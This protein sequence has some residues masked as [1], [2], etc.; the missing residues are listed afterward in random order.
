M[1][2]VFVILAVFF[3]A[4]LAQ[5]TH[6]SHPPAQSFAP[7]TGQTF[8]L[9]LDTAESAYSQWR[10]DDL[11]SLSA[12]RATIRVLRVRKAAKWDPAFSLWLQKT[13]AGQMRN[14]VELQLVAPHGKPPLLIRVV[15]F[16]GGKSVATESSNKTIGL[17]ENLTVEIAWGTP[18]TATIKIGDSETHKVSIPWLIDS[19]GVSVSTGEMEV[20][21][22]VLG[23]V[24]N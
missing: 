3:G 16:E 20:N 14:R 19:V 11:G 5:D 7:A 4:A 10:H 8:Y 24:G 1:R 18:H 15:Q 23:G 2:T 12:M 21:P 13:E 6:Q 17:N 9:D 22:L